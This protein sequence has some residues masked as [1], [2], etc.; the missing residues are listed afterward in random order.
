M[1]FVFGLLILVLASMVS[2][3]IP[4][5]IEARVERRIARA[6]RIFMERTSHMSK[7]RLRRLG[8]CTVALTVAGPLLKPLFVPLCQKGVDALLN[9]VKNTLCTFSKLPDNI[10][11]KCQQVVA[12]VQGKWKQYGAS[13]CGALWDALMT[14]LKTLC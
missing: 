8:L 14:F 7:A 11:S 6:E 3:R 12:W 4:H 10:K 9:W 2:C 1:K 13:G 5:D